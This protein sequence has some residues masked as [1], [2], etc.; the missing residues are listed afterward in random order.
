MG[1][2]YCGLILNRCI[3][4]G[5]KPLK[6]K[7]LVSHNPFCLRIYGSMGSTDGFM[8][9][10]QL[11]DIVQTWLESRVLAVDLA[12]QHIPTVHIVVYR[13]RM[14]TESETKNIAT[15]PNRDGTSS[16]LRKIKHH[17]RTKAQGWMGP[18]WIVKIPL[19]CWCNW[20]SRKWWW[21]LSYVIL[22]TRF[23][24]NKWEM[25][26][27]NCLTNAMIGALLGYCT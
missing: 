27:M 26:L 18:L 8:S 1:S 2:L 4:E 6:S 23:D 15:C 11:L 17:L 22:I 13:C 16:L 21:L 10:C 25:W 24:Q 3:G 20:M 5:T 19:K 14:W 12:S 9:P 7:L